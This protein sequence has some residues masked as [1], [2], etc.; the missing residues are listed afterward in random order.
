MRGWLCAVVAAATARS[1]AARI[2]RGN[3]A[4]AAAAADDAA[5]ATVDDAPPVAAAR[6]FTNLGTCGRRGRW[7]EA[8]EEKLFFLKTIKTA[9]STTRFLFMR[10]ARG[11]RL[12][13]LRANAPGGILFDQHA[14]SQ[15]WLPRNKM[16]AVPGGSRPRPAGVSPYDIAADHSTLDLPRLRESLPGAR[17]VTVSRGVV[18][19]VKSAIRMFHNEATPRAHSGGVELSAGPFRPNR[20]PK[21]NLGGES[22]GDAAALEREASPSFLRRRS[23]AQ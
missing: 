14:S 9:G 22:R 13:P 12:A 2:K 15:T 4:A 8:V 5:A 3:A 16:R 21:N 7:G 6:N 17:W 11:E 23:D 10:F 1:G 20:S 19:R 18:S